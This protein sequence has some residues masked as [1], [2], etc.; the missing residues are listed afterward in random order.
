M[1][2]VQFDALQEAYERT[3]I[4]GGRIYNLL[5]TSLWFLQF[6][7]WKGENTKGRTRG[8]CTFVNPSIVW[9]LRDVQERR[10]VK[11]MI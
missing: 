10:P 9:G 11:V 6:L 4:A 1:E 2:T 8:W 3:V 7:F 5:R